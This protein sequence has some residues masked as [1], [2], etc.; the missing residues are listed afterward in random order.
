MQ[1][2]KPVDKP[3]IGLEYEV[4]FTLLRHKKMK[5]YIGSS[6]EIGDKPFVAF[7]QVYISAAPIE[8]RYS[9]GPEFNL[10]MKCDCSLVGDGLLELRTPPVPLRQL[11]REIKKLEAG[12]AMFAV[13]LAKKY[14]PV[15]VFLPRSE[16]N[17][18]AR[19]PAPS[20]HCNLSWPTGVP[21][22]LF[23]DIQ[24]RVEPGSKHVMRYHLF[25]PYDFT[26]YSSL[27]VES[28]TFK[29]YAYPEKP[30]LVG[31]VMAE[32]WQRYKGLV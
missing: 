20:K 7:G 9:G 21:R 4:Q 29:D 31:F 5:V 10:S 30:H 16:Y 18:R 22:R 25:V 26:N 6:T 3:L 32:K 24:Y 13:G 2:K 1:R 11:K 23:K 14:G 28:G 19:M 12:L 15:G 8:L 27:F 17:T